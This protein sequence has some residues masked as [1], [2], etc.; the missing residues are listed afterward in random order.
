MG[1]DITQILKLLVGPEVEKE[2]KRLIDDVSFLAGLAIREYAGGNEQDAKYAIENLLTEVDIEIDGQRPWDIQAH[3]E[4]FYRRVLASGSLAFGETYMEGMWDADELDITLLKILRGG[5]DQKVRDNPGILLE[6]V[7]AKL[8]N[9]QKTRAI[10]VCTK[11]YDLGNDF[12]KLM[13]DDRM[14]YTCGYWENAFNLEE[15]QEAKLEL[16]AKKIGLKPGQKVLDIGCGFGSLLKY[17]AEKYD[18]RGVGITL[19]VEQKKFAE[20]SC[21]GLPVEIR[22]QDYR[23]VREKF[24]H[25][26]SIGMAEAVGA[27]NFRNYMQ[28]ARNCLKD[29]GLFLLHTIVGN[30]TKN[31]IDPWMGKY[32]FPNGV[33]PS[34]AL[35]NRSAEGLFVVEDT[36]QFPAESYPETLQCWQDNFHDGKDNLIGPLADP[37]FHRMI[38]F[39]LMASKA[40]FMARHIHLYQFVLSKDG[41]VG[42]DPVR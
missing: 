38:D 7:K 41:L 4:S 22:F 24:D 15:A 29:N 10:E 32:I 42:Y 23:D 27:K 30:K 36:H 11:H 17:F 40:S 3:E 8:F 26:V 5:L 28:V 13:L 1:E 16:V 6:A 31:T 33:L 35:I 12:F 14:V 20:E 19:S 37:T 9:P 39:Y 25:V 34:L 21:K 18:V 2:A